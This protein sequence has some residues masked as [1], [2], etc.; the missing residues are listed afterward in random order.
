[1]QEIQFIH[2]L[3]D[4]ELESVVG[5]AGTA[6]TDTKLSVGTSVSTTAFAI[7]NHDYTINKTQSKTIITNMAGVSYSFGV[8]VAIAMK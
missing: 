2:T 1:M 4:E 8:A 5:G 6:S 7:G 3:S